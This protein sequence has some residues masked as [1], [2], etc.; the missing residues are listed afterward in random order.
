MGTLASNRKGFITG[1]SQANYASALN[2]ATGTAT[3]SATGNQNCIQYFKSS[4]RGGG[5]F[6]FIRTFI[7][8]NTTNLT[9]ASSISL[10]LTSAGGS[11]SSNFNVTA[12]KHSAGSS[13]GSQI[14]D[15]D[16]NNIDRN[17][18]YSAATSFASSGTITFSLNAA[19]ATQINENNDFNVALLLTHD[20]IQT[21]E[22]PLEEDGNITN[23]IAFSSAINLVYTEPAAPSGYTHK[24]LGVAS[25]NIGKVNTVATANIGKVI[26]VD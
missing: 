19:A 1:T 9:E 14:S 18:A 10:Q 26:T 21:E 7:H 15:S 4:G 17:T 5:T 2:V 25:A 13:N 20:A 16:F 11:N 3:D 24:V 8:F 12:I 6:R 22:D 23:S